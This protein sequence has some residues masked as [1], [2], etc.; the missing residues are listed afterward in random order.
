[1]PSEVRYRP[2]QNPNPSNVVD[3]SCTNREYGIKGGNL[4]VSPF[5][6]EL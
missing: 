3:G 5:Y 1:M 6:Q 2:Q 4:V